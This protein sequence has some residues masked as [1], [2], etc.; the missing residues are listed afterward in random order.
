MEVMEEVP[1]VAKAK[2][3]PPDTSEKVQVHY[4]QAVEAEV[5]MQM[6]ELVVV[7]MEEDGEE[8]DL[9]DLLILEEVVVEELEIMMI[10]L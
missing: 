6:A 10:I 2:V 1:T 7:E 9:Q 3:L 8:K 5:Y 4:M